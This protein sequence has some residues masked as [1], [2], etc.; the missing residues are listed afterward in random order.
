MQA[1]PSVRLLFLSIAGILLG[2]AFPAYAKIYLC[3]AAG[4]GALSFF[5]AVFDLFF[6]RY[7]F[8][9]SWPASYI[10]SVI[11]SFAALISFQE[12]RVSHNSI[13]H[14][15]NDE[16][17]IKGKILGKPNISENHA[18]W[19]M[20][21]REIIVEI[22]TLPVS[23]KVRVW[24]SSPRK[25][26]IALQ[27]GEFVWA[28]GKLKLPEP[29]QNKGEIDFAKY[30]ASKGIYAELKSY[31]EGNLQQ[32][33]EVDLSIFEQFLVK[34]TYDFID[35]SIEKLI[36]FGDEKS[37]IKAILLGDKSGLSDEI[38]LAFQRTGTFHVLA[39]SGLHVGLFVLVLGAFSQRFK[40]SRSGKWVVFLI[41]T[42]VLLLYA[43]V[44]GA[45]PPV[46]RAVLMAI[47]FLGTTLYEKKTYAL[48][49]LAFADFL[50]LLISPKDLFSL[51]FLLSNAAVISIILLY[52]KLISL[53]IFDNIESSK[54]WLLPQIGGIVK[55]IW[56][57]IALTISAS[58][59]VSPILGLTFGSVPLLGLLANLPVTFLVS[60]AVYAMLPALFFNLCCAEF[61]A[62]YALCAWFFI[63]V[64]IQI[65]N[66]FSQFSFAAISINASWLSALSFY[67]FIGFLFNLYN[68]KSRAKWTIF[69]LISLNFILFGKLFFE[70]NKEEKLIINDLRK[71]V[72][73]LCKTQTESIVIDVG[74]SDYD[75]TRTLK[76]VQVFHALPSA[77]LQF[78]SS[79]RII[80][81]AATAPIFSRKE[82]QLRL[83]TIGVFRP[84]KNVMKVMTK[85]QQVL[86]VKKVGVLKPEPFYRV[87]TLI[88]HLR[89]FSDADEVRLRE[90][91]N[92]AKPERVVFSTSPFM[93]KSERQKL[94]KLIFAE[95]RYFSPQIN[96]QLVFD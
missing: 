55:N 3:A 88:L 45:A 80:T 36:P 20:E 56:Q 33:N 64:S 86:F 18:Y 93:R 47:V 29:T 5:L 57:A 82:H 67:L 91:V 17:W 77:F 85:T 44:T 71:G 41:S 40:Q 12:T 31:G 21:V 52:P 37:F 96:G 15:L 73:V 25:L 62:L 27:D 4:L 22:D 90:W 34:P 8:L 35:H 26:D 43:A 59:G 65:S 72:S 14:Y 84:N 92:F 19:D 54:Y 58:L 13:L 2:E 83:K 7:V 9:K 49:T 78:A 1:Y 70:K 74:M 38:K 60:L 48:N 79:D 75:A 51:S 50:I 81:E 61:A 66:W 23:G 24:Q 76:Q 30:L 6:K 11:F 32:I 63:R 53:A 94:H 28:F 46:K 87:S 95:A 89:K 39:I 42:F 10:F 16:H 69:L 68:Q